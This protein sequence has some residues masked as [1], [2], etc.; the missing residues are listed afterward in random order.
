MM[1]CL[2]T[3]RFSSTVDVLHLVFIKHLH[4]CVLFFSLEF[5]NYDEDEVA[6]ADEEDAPNA[7][8]TRFIDN[9]GWSSRTR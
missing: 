7:E 5:L 8:E 1:N 9:S 3:F 4:L 2:T 6:E